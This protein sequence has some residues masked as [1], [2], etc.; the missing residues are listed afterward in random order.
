MHLAQASEWLTGDPGKGVAVTAL[1]AASYPQ[2]DPPDGGQWGGMTRVTDDPAPTFQAL[3]SDC[4][5]T[6]T[7]KI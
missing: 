6:C 7:L 5:P 3:K 2:S 4:C 1:A